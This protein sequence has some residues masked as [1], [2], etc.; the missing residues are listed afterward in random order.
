[1]GDGGRSGGSS[2]RLRVAVKHSCQHH[3]AMHHMDTC[4]AARRLVSRASHPPS[5]GQASVGVGVGAG[6]SAEGEQPT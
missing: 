3:T 1:M 5:V 6:V 4:S 2:F